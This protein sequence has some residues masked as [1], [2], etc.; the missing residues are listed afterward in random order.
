[1]TSGC[2]TGPGWT[3]YNVTTRTVAC[4]ISDVAPMS[5]ETIELHISGKHSSYDLKWD[6]VTCEIVKTSTGEVLSASTGDELSAQ[7][8]LQYDLASV[9]QGRF[10]STLH[11]IG[12]AIGEFDYAGLGGYQHDL[13]DTDCEVVE[14]TVTV[15]PT[16]EEK[17]G[18]GL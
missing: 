17:A 6:D 3:T 7:C 15:E 4:S 16:A 13:N 12:T 14:E 9:Y 10:Q 18:L 1:M 5:G 11:G 2:G 8:I